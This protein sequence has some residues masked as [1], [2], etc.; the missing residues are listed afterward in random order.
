MITPHVDVTN[1]EGDPTSQIISRKMTVTKNRSLDDPLGSS[2]DL[3]KMMAMVGAFYWLV[4]TALVV[5]VA[6]V[7]TC[8]LCITPLLLVSRTLFNRWEHRL[9]RMV[10]DHWVSAGQYTGVKVVEY[11]NDIA[12]ISDKRCLFLS[13]HLGL[14]DHF[15]LMTAMH[16]KHTLTG[17]YLW[18]IYNIWKY[19]P[20]GLMWTAHGNFFINGGASK[21]T[22]V[23]NTFRKHLRK[24]YWEQDYG[25]VVMY[26][27]GSRFFLI[28]DSG[29]RFAEKNGLKPLKHCAYPRTGAAHTVLSEC[30]PKEDRED[31]IEYIVDCTLG[32]PKGEV[33]DLGKAMTGEWPSDNTTVAIH[34]RIYRTDASMAD[35]KVL[36]KW[37]YERYEEKDQLLDDFYKSGQFESIPRHVYFPFSRAIMV[38]F[39]W[40]ALFYGHYLL[41]MKPVT[42]FGY[43]VFMNLLF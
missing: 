33:V 22:S 39:F 4:M 43:R 28:K 41:W 26:P 35:E 12:K 6:C 10:N 16:N 2:M 20:L 38:Q 30:G 23:L 31:P 36:Q 1:P 42:V 27:E 19:T 3:K 25:F 24:Y 40:M 8:V 15:I 9:C 32:Y 18:V 17:R 14:V 5:P 29:A 13:N 34:Y 37:L 7:A 11:G 21:R